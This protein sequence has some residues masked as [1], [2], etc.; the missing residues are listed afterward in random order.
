MAKRAINT[1]VQLSQLPDWLTDFI[2]RN[3]HPFAA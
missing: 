3:R 2:Y 1:R